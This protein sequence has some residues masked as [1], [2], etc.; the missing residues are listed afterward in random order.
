MTIQTQC[1]DRREMVKRISEHLQMPAVYLRVPSCAYRIG[2]ITVTKDASITG[3]EKQIA[4]LLPFLKKCGYASDDPTEA[5]FTAPLEGWTIPQ[6]INLIR[7][8]CSRQ[9]LIRRMLKLEE[10][11][12]EASFAE[13]ITANTPE[14]HDAL[15]ARLKTAI[16]AECMR[17]MSITSGMLRISLGADPDQGAA[18]TLFTKLLNLAQNASRIRLTTCDPESEKY[19][20]HAMLMQ[21][22]LNGA[23]HRQLRHTLTTHLTGYAAFKSEADMQA[24]K[25]RQAQLRRSRREAVQA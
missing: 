18:I 6:T 5:E 10:F 3:E 16:H 15:E 21:L 24:H 23:E 14:T 25:A 13:A 20:A 9:H 7:L 22:G 4:A 19:A 11:H 2:Q 1:T 8:L 17:G 12:I